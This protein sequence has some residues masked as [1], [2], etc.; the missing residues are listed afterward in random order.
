MITV[1]SRE[2]SA[3]DGRAISSGNIPVF[4]LCILC[5]SASSEISE[6]THEPTVYVSNF[7][8]DGDDE[9]Y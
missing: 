4:E 8:I 3:F 9:P 5:A 1:I 2:K 6:A 7:D